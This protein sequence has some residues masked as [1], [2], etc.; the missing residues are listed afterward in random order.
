M[1]KILLESKIIVDKYCEYI[2]N[3]YDIHNTTSE[4]TKFYYE[5][6]RRK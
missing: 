2:F 1:S 6:L 3:N 5:I 4:L